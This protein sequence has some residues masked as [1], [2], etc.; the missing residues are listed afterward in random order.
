MLS[1]ED[2]WGVDLYRQVVLIST[3]IGGECS[4]SSTGRLTP[5]E[6]SPTTQLNRKI[7]GPQ[8]RSGCCEQK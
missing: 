8:G 7:D 3:L 6:S 2:L 5:T 1:H 4:A